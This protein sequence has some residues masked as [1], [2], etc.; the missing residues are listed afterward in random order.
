MCILA[1]QMTGLTCGLKSPKASAPVL[2]APREGVQC[3]VLCLHSFLAE[4]RGTSCF[5][6]TN[7]RAG[8]RSHR[9]QKKILPVESISPA[10]AAQ[11]KVTWYSSIRCSA[12]LALG[13][14]KRKTLNSAFTRLEA[15]FSIV[16]TSK[17][18]ILK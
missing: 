2:T 3:W 10:N 12:T 17:R 4:P 8:L 11:T 18:T 7:D 5:G 16:E 6:K 15:F 9:L 13:F 1:S 14:C